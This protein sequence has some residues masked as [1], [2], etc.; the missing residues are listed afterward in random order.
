MG[1]NHTHEPV[2]DHDLGPAF[3]WA[4]I[5]NVSYVLI[6]A[7]AGFAIDSLSLLADAAHSVDGVRSPEVLYRVVARCCSGLG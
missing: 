7:G 1:N 5:L 2:A 4:I 3:K 6:E